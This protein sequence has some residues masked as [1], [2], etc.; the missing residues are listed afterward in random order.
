MPDLEYHRAADF[1]AKEKRSM[2]RPSKCRVLKEI[3]GL[4]VKFSEE[5]IVYVTFY[6]R[7]NTVDIRSLER[8]ENGF[9]KLVTSV[10]K[11]KVEKLNKSQKMI[12]WKQTN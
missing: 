5:E 11:D 9:Y 6:K 2:P 3:R 8:Q 4:E 7:K 1:I 10:S 12:I